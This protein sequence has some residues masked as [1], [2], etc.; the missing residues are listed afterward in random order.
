MDAVSVCCTSARGSCSPWWS[1]PATASNSELKPHDAGCWRVQ[2]A[3][4]GPYWFRI[5]V[6]QCSVFDDTDKNG[7]D[8][9]V[10]FS[11]GGLRL[12][13]NQVS[14]SSFFHSFSLSFPFVFLSF[15]LDCLNFEGMTGSRCCL[16]FPECSSSRTRS[17]SGD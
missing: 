1:R 17:C 13:Q 9:V 6:G 8:G 4:C 10:C 16:F 14:C 11:G 3:S 5:S 12:R 15:L 2:R 7:D